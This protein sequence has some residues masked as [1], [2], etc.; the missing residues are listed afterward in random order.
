MTLTLE[1]VRKVRFPMVKRPGEGYRAIEVDDFVD[2]V[3]A[4][5]MT[6]TDENERLKAQVEALRS[7][8]P[9]NRGRIRISLTRTS[10]CVL[11]LRTPLSAEW[12]LGQF[13]RG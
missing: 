4:A 5:F 12:A 11:R 1:E 9:G 3:E 13:R 7:G 2:K 6:L 10:T 8:E